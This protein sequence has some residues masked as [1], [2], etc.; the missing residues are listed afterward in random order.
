MEGILPQLILVAVL[1]LVNA[2]FAAA[3]MAFVSINNNRVNILAAQGD[4]KAQL[5]QKVLEE[6]TKLLSTIQV[7]ITLAGFFSSASA[8]TGI[9]GRLADVL[10]K[11]PMLIKFP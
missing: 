10:E 4:M 3:E 5:L 8:A 2:F 7:G 11:F 6:P 1:T 9:A